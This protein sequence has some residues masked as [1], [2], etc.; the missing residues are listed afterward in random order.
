MTSVSCR[1]FFQALASRSKIVATVMLTCAA[2]SSCIYTVQPLSGQQFKDDTI[3]GAWVAQEGGKAVNRIEINCLKSN[4]YKLTQIENTNNGVKRTDFQI[5]PTV[6]PKHHYM[7][8]AFQTPKDNIKDPQF[9]KDYVTVYM[10]YKY[11]VRGNKLTASILNYDKF[12]DLIHSHKLSGMAS[13]TTWG[14]TVRI[15]ESPA[16]LLALIDKDNNDEFFQ[17][18]VVFEKSLK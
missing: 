16:K 12:S 7:N 11:T 8:V 6:T 5:F 10:I 15:A 18:E 17:D 3:I 14:Q 2:M 9:P 13:N 4:L 1:E